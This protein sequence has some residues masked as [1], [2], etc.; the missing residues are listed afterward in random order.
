MRAPFQFGG[1]GGGA[2][3]GLRGNG[4]R[5]AVAA[6]IGSAVRPEEVEGKAGGR[7]AGGACSVVARGS[8]DPKRGNGGGGPVGD[9][10]IIEDAREEEDAL[11]GGGP[12]G[13]ENCPDVGRDGGIGG[14][15]AG[16]GTL[17]AR[18]ADG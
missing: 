4:M 13:F 2:A 3:G 18:V 12:A 14:G 11:S 10:G 6:G 16:G 7:N 1:L 8:G 9:V 15:G 17:M 5:C